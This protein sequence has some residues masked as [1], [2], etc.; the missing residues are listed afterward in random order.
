MAFHEYASS[1][2]RQR[3]LDLLQLLSTQE[4]V[5][6][7]LRQYREAG[8]IRH[9]SLEWLRDLYVSVVG[10][11]FD[12]SQPPGR[13]DDFVEHLLKLP[14]SMKTVNRK[15]E[16][17]DPLRIAEDVLDSRTEVCREWKEC[18][19]M[20]QLEHMELRKLILAYQMGNQPT[21]PSVFAHVEEGLASEATLQGEFE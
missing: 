7:V 9:V 11:Y 12:G 6:R 20:A 1:P 17:V 15:V 4:A 16:L 10:D 18:L 3:N 14:P 8:D 19:G 21:A 13:G 2:L 5:H